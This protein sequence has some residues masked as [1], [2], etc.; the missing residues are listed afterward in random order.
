MWVGSYY[1]YRGIVNQK[2]IIY[3]L[4]GKI[5]ALEGGEEMP[6][7]RTPQR[8]NESSIRHAAHGK[9][10]G[11]MKCEL[12]LQIDLPPEKEGIVCLGIIITR[13]EVIG[14][15]IRIQCLRE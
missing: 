1:E 6:Y 3:E 15:Y 7:R 2:A 8:K 10:M 4:S 12:E 9:P 5:R 14:T 13:K 11:R